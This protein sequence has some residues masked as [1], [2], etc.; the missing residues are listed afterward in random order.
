MFTL[1]HIAL[2]LVVHVKAGESH[3]DTNGLDGVDGLS[4]P[5]DGDA[6]DGDAFDQG[7][8]RVSYRGGGREDDESDDIL[9]EVDG[10]VEEEIVHDRVGSGSTF[11]VIASKVGVMLGSII[12]GHEVGEVV[13]EPN[14]DHE[15]EGHA[16][17]I[18]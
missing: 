4:E 5:E 6:N 16:G 18:E 9:G 17:G 1:F 3:G 2:G 11:F 15:D 7:S 14:G 13:V 10:A 8:D 12:C